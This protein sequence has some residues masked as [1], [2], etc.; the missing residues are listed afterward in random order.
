MACKVRQIR[1]KGKDIGMV[2]VPKTAAPDADARV[3][4]VQAL[5]RIALDRGMKS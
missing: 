4:L 5:I 1:R 3:A 2:P